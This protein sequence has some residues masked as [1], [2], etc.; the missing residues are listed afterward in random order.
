VVKLKVV[1]VAPGTALHDVPPFVLTIHCTVGVGVPVAAAVNVAALPADTVTEV[2]LVVITIE[3]TVSVAGLDVTLP[4]EFVN[5]ASYRL[6]FCAAVVVKL[7]P[8]EV[9]PA[10]AV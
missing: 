10:T 7:K 1:E 6:P 3:L 8:V 2:G 5:T 4:A 9:A